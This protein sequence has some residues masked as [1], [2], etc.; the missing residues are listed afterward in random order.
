MR[1][2]LICFLLFVC[3][4]E[5][6]AAAR[7]RVAVASNFLSPLQSMAKSFEKETGHSL[8]ISAGS[9]GKL[10]SQIVNGA[11]FDVF[12][13]ANSTE[14][15]RLESS[16]NSVKGSRFT[17]GLGQLVLWAPQSENNDKSIQEIL[18]SDGL[19]RLSVANPLTAPYGAAAVET[20]YKLGVY[21]SLEKKI[22]RGENVSQ[23]YQFVASGAAQYGFIAQSQLRVEERNNSKG[24]WLV[25]R[26]LY[27]PITQQAVLLKRGE[28]NLAARQ[29]LEFLQ[30]NTGRTAIESFGYALPDKKYMP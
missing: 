17:Y 20:L 22:I 14:P 27:T 1:V 10:Y 8:R 23:A 24:Y 18:D 4:S 11:P 15:S 6:A 12:L 21:Q 19:S 9:T 25:D 26:S 2:G 13:A 30:S 16:G 28:N 5:T 29:F 3:L 7:V